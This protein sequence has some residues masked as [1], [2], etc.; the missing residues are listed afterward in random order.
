MQQVSDAH[1]ES[2][3]HQPVPALGGKTPMEALLDSVPLAK[4]KM[5]VV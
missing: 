5:L 4:E 2:W 3:V 1:W